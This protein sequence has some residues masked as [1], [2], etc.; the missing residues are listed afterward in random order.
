MVLLL[1]AAAAA[2]PGADGAIGRWR[3]E[4]KNAIIE[5]APCAA[6]ICGRLVSSDGIK[7]NP[8]LRDT[9]NKDPAL[10]TRKLAGL[11]ILSGFTRGKDGWTDGQLYKADDGGTYKGTL[12]PVDAD[13]LRVRGCIVWPLCKSQTWTRV[14]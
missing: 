4:T 9:A 11:Q 5:I 12:T 8:D 7:A 6:S 13:H 14:R 10:R 1:L 2:S 3:T